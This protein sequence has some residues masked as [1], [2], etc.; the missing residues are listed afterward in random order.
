[1]DDVD[2]WRGLLCFDILKEMEGGWGA[3]EKEEGMG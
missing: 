2:E 1:V 3:D